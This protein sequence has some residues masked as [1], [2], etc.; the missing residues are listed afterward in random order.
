MILLHECADTWAL[1]DTGHRPAPRRV[2]QLSTHS[3]TQRH[4]EFCQDGCQLRI[5]QVCAGITLAKCFITGTRTLRN[6]IMHLH[7]L[8]TAQ[9]CQAT[10]KQ[11]NYTSCSMM[12]CQIPKTLNLCGGLFL[13][14]TTLCL[15]EPTRLLPS[16]LSFYSPMRGLFHLTALKEEG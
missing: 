10:L 11:R 4:L 3:L 12:Q 14:S 15:W 6:A 2:T 9:Y 8:Y 7:N 5:N 13:Q 16:L 1:L